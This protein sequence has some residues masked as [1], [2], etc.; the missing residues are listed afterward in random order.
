[1]GVSDKKFIPVITYLN[2]DRD[3]EIL[4][5]LETQPNRSAA[6]REILQG[7]IQS[8]V[9]TTSSSSGQAIQ[10]NLDSIRATMAEALAQHLDLSMLR[11]LIEVAIASALAG[12]P[13]IAAAPLTQSDDTS[14]VLDNLDD[15]LVWD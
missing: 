14:S 9:G 6:I 4:A 5:W 3:Q 8:T 2:P 11:Q 7:H 12:L 15:N 10:I 1:M 13:G